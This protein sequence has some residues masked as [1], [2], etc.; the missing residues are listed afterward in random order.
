M[1][2][3]PHHSRALLLSLSESSELW[4]P[5]MFAA[6]GVGEAGDAALGNRGRGIAVLVVFGRVA[7][8]AMG[9]DWER[10]PAAMV[11]IG[12]GAGGAGMAQELEALRTMCSM[13]LN[14]TCQNEDQLLRG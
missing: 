1:A 7:E 4:L 14:M 3:M 9:S 11:V 2:T 13:A 5:V 12:M 6:G 8:G 10:G